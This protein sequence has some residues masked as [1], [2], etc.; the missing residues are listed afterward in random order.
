M[1][2]FHGFS[3]IH[4]RLQRLFCLPRHDDKWTVT[5]LDT[6]LYKETS[7]QKCLFRNLFGSLRWRDLPIYASILYLKHL[8]AQMTCMFEGQPSKTIPKIQPRQGYL[9]CVP[10]ISMHIK[11]V[12]I[13]LRTSIYTVYYIWTI[14]CVTK[15]TKTPCSS[16]PS[17]VTGWST[18][19][20]LP[21]KP[22]MRKWTCRSILKSHECGTWEK[23]T[24]TSNKNTFFLVS[25]TEAKDCNGFWLGNF[26]EAIPWCCGRII[27]VGKVCHAGVFERM[28]S[29]SKTN[30]NAQ[31][32][33]A[34][35]IHN[36][37]SFY[38]ACT[39]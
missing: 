21:A 12:Y 10:S 33:W 14:S 15:F 30:P 9:H 34:P 17:G 37:E 36:A 39:N 13:Q 23:N 31:K 7:L 3:H 18:S 2:D 19:H 6:S 1:K 20:H 24:S 32:L 29:A 38:Q 22:G 11:Y 8:K 25:F 35:Q 5:S 28:S 4:K 16:S 26:F 27:P